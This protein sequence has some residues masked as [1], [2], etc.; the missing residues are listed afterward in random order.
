MSTEPY[1]NASS[2]AEHLA[3]AVAAYL[4]AREKGQTPDPEECVRCHP[5]IA[6]ELRDFLKNYQPFD[7]VLAP[8]REKSPDAGMVGMTFG[9]YEVLEEIARGGIGIVYRARQKSLNRLVALKMILDPKLAGPDEVRR[10][11]TEAESAAHLDHPHIVPIY[12]VDE[13]QGQCFS[14]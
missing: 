5:D 6:E 10:F 1:L 14:R 11:R 12:E 3:D 4:D 7:D 2:N 8:L 13:Y 9:D